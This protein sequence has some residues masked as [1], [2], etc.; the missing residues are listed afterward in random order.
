MMHHT[1][2]KLYDLVAVR[3]STEHILQTLVLK[4]DCADIITFD[5]TDAKV[6]WLLKGKVRGAT[7]QVLGATGKGGTGVLHA[8]G[9]GSCMS[10]GMLLYLLGSLKVRIASR[11]GKRTRF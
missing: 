7:G 5:P 2:V 6:P 3:A 10:I 8:L 11:M 4:G 1:T 9:E